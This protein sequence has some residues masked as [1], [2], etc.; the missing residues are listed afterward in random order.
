MKI[1]IDTNVL[2][3]FMCQREPFYNDVYA[4]FRKAA[5]HEIDI[6]VSALTVVNTQ[7]TARKYGLSMEDVCSAIRNILTLISV[8]PIDGEMV[9]QAYSM[10]DKDKEDVL[11]FL[12]AR[13]VGA[14]IIVSRDK[15]GFINSPVPVFTP[16]EYLENEV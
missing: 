9:R 12:S 3:D 1:F 10:T 14:D 2:L 5:L 11:Q 13:S 16:H 7:Y 6:V 15:K 4:I 8:S